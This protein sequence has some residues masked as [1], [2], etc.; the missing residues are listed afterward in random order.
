M[1]GVLGNTW[2]L[3]LGVMLL[4]V[5]NGV[6]AS[7]L[8]I[9]GAIEGFS[10]YQMSLVMSAYFVG[11]LG[12]SRLAPGMIRRVGH[13]RVFAALGSLISAVLILYATIPDWIVWTAMRVV[14]GFC[15]A[16]VYVTAESWLNDSATNETRGQALSAYMIVQMIGIIAAQALLNAGDPSGFLLFVIPSVLVSLAFTP[17]LLK[18]GTAPAFAETRRLPFRELLRASPLGCAGMLMTGGIYS[19]MFGMGAVWGS[20]VGLTVA[21][22]SIFVGIMYVG[23]LLLQYPVG[24]LS[25]RMDRRRLILGL[26][27]LG[28]AAMLFAGLFA[29]S[30]PMFVVLAFVLGGVVNPLYSLLIAHTNDFLPRESMA[31]GSAG[32]L[33]INGLGAIAGPLVTGWMMSVIGP[34]GFFLFIA[35]LLGLLALYALWRMSRRAAPVDTGNFAVMA[36]SASVVAVEAV[37]EGAQ[38]AGE[39]AAE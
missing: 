29:T 39:P 7:L 3:L 14:I 21:E 33:F 4:M 9:R 1:I 25:D 17:I 28:S 32:L 10:T 26:A 24:W 15:F 13:V 23:G 37:L 11:F 18:A 8:G 19:A 31:A 35:A 16:G 5:G 6:Q 30:F 20:L 22:I 27:A 12:G 2:P 34:G 38:S 36:P